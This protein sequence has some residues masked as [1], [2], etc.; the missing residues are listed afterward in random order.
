MP[1]VSQSIIRPIVPGR[2][3]DAGLAVA[4]A[5]LLAAGHGL[6]P[7][8]LGGRQQLGRQQLLVDVG[9]GD[10]MLAQHAE[11]VLLVG[12]EAAEGPHAAGDAGARGVGVARSS[13]R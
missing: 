13:T 6:V 5:E 2:R 11:H 4:D 12:R 7:R 9:R 8:Q 3:E 1:V 10:T